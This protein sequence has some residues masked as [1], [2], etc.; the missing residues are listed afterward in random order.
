VHDVASFLGRFHPVWVHLPIGIFVLL[1]LLEV[2]GLLSRHPRLSWLPAITRGQ[3]GL[4]LAAGAG[5]AVV[6]AALGWMLARDGDYDLAQVGRHQ[7]L[8]IAAACAALLLLAVHRLRWIY[9]PLLAV[10]LVLLAVAADAGGKIT[11]GSDYLT[12]RMPAPIARILGISAAAAPKPRAPDFDTAVAYADVVQPILQERCV[13]CHGAAKSNGDLRLDTWELLA[14]GGKHGAVLKPGDLAG[15]ALVRRVELPVEEKE[16]MP[17]RGKPQL[18]DDDLTLVEWW[19][20]AGAPR[21][22]RVATLE[23]PSSVQVILEG[24]LT[25]G[26]ADP[27]PDRAA[28]LALA[29]QI[30]ARLGII[31]RSLSPD[32]PWLDVSARSAGGNFND[33]ELAQLAPVAQAVEWLDLGDTAVTD[34]GLA[35]VGEMRRLRRLHLDQLKVTDSGLA[36]LSRLRQLEYLNLRGTLVTDKGLAALRTLPRLRS[37]YVWQTAVTPAAVKALGDALI[38]RR[39]I[40]RWREDEAELERRIHEEHFEGN[41]GEELL[42]AS[43]PLTESDARAPAAGQPKLPP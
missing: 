33:G 5:A 11:H 37:L 30:S 7:W 41:T 28:T 26:A 8:G 32:G 14:K 15:S 16:H 23:L 1:G 4:I 38:D 25:G 39:R 34:A 29:A 19:V 3:R 21:A 6:T 10:S 27:P 43:K 17:P 9:P 18:S 36:R 22:R 42:P 2:A 40:A 12:A 35:S 20:G 24:R 13:A 31:I